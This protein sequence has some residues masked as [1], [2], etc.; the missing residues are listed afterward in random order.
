MENTK[1]ENLMEPI[2]DL[3]WEPEEEVEVIA[4][5]IG[6]GCN[7]MG[8]GCGGPGPTPPPLPHGWCLG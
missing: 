1:V 5:Y 8:G 3:I 2:I 6:N 7:G 4:S